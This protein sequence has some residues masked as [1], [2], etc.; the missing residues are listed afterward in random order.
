[1]GADFNF[2]IHSKSSAY[3]INEEDMQEYE[4]KVQAKIQQIW[5]QIEQKTEKLQKDYQNQRDA[6]IDEVAEL[7]YEK[8]AEIKAEFKGVDSSD[9]E[10]MAEKDAKLKQIQ[11]EMDKLKQE[12]LGEAQ[13]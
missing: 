13:K 11:D 6:I 12:K 8:I 9:E 10:K 4:E 2:D 7:K 5:T 3:F 1:M